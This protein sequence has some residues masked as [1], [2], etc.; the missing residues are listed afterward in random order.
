MRALLLTTLL[1][2]ACYSEDEASISQSGNVTKNDDLTTVS[3]PA[4]IQ[5]G[6][7]LIDIDG[8]RTLGEKVK[9]PRLGQCL[10]SSK[11]SWLFQAE[12]QEETKHKN[13]SL[14]ILFDTSFS[15][16]TTDPKEL[17]YSSFKENYLLPLYKQIKSAKMS[18][19]I[20]I[21]P[22]KYCNVGE[23]T[24]HFNHK[25][26]REVFKDDI[27]KLIG[28]KPPEKPKS[29]E[30]PKPKD[31]KGHGANGSTNYLESFDKAANFLNKA[32]K[33]DLK[34][35]L[36]V[37]D[38]L[39][40]TFN[41]GK[42]NTIKY[43]APSCDALSIV[44]KVNLPVDD[45]SDFD[46]YVKNL[47][48]CVISEHY[49]SED[50]R[51]DKLSEDPSKDE[52]SEYKC[53]APGQGDMGVSDNDRKSGNDEKAFND[54]YNH[55]LGMIQHSRVMD[56]AKH[57][58]GIYALLLKVPCS[59]MKLGENNKYIHEKALCN[60]ISK[61]AEPFLDSF[62]DQH[63]IVDNANQLEGGL[64]KILTYQ[65]TG[66]AYI[67]ASSGKGNNTTTVVDTQTK[68]HTGNLIKVG[69]DDKNDNVY[70][71]AGEA[72]NT[73]T[74]A[75]GLANK[76]GG[77]FVIN[78][79]FTF[80]STDACRSSGSD[81]H[82]DTRSK[83]EVNKYTNSGYTAWCLLSPRCDTRTQCCD[84]NNIYRELTDAEGQHLCAAKG[85]NWI[86][87][88]VEGKQKVCAC[89]CDPTAVAACQGKGQSWNANTC[90]CDTVTVPPPAPKCTSSDATFCCINGKKS[91]QPSCGKGDTL[92]IAA[93]RCNSSPPPPQQSCDPAAAASCNQETHIW[94]GFPACSCDQKPPILIEP[95]EPPVLP[96]S[97]PQGPDKNGKVTGG[98]D[99]RPEP[100]V[101]RGMVW[102]KYDSF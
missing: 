90:R 17:R 28:T 23:Y 14:A 99:Q 18:A 89:V 49:L 66:T 65:V 34:Q 26:P 3:N 44:N 73:L 50:L 60:N 19:T 98:E 20:K 53:T 29:P 86:W 48:D 100:A 77:N 38:G 82:I 59:Q 51:K 46:E 74:V 63:V 12:I 42:A 22:F 57:D 40:L 94:T 81:K 43:D 31:L 97:N 58:F 91:P 68:L 70:D 36:I 13:L 78:Y 11:L 39:P 52:L 69:R 15:L 6:E 33:D 71:Y 25:T 27:D 16:K 7:C 24:L 10:P 67:D 85:G 72:N 101:N 76:S 37:S 1:I 35:L 83:L 2:T 55:I 54:P 41:G 92:D 93:C 5:P 32:L 87:V 4:Y 88:G 102:G 21:Y 47:E 9:L 64:I 75:H 62:T 84:P 96:P 30:K 45:P 95:P 79:N 8:M 80:G 61:L 56:K